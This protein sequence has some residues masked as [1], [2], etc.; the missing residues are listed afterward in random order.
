[1]YS[2]YGIQTRQDE[3]VQIVAIAIPRKD[4]A[5]LGRFIDGPIQESQRYSSNLGSCLGSKLFLK[6]LC[7]FII[8]VYAYFH[9]LSLFS[10]R[11]SH[12]LS[13]LSRL[14]GFRTAYSRFATLGST[15]VPLGS[16]TTKYI[17]CIGPLT[18]SEKATSQ[19]GTGCVRNSWVSSAPIWTW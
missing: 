1:M 12:F 14:I 16:T 19:N 7:E 4:H 9:I 15:T 2:F 17:W 5:V 8:D 13:K 10:P 18:V 11:K 3:F 6:S